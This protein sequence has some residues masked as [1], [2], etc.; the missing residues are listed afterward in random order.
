MIVVSAG[1]QL[2]TLHLRPGGG[3]KSLGKHS[4]WKLGRLVGKYP[5]HLMKFDESSVQS[6][7]KTR[8]R[9]TMLS[10]FSYFCVLFLPCLGQATCSKYLL[11]KVGNWYSI[12]HMYKSILFWFYFAVVWRTVLCICVC[13]C[14]CFLVFWR[15]LYMY[16]CI[17]MYA[18]YIQHKS[19]VFHWFMFV[20]LSCGSRMLW[21]SCVLLFR[22]RTGLHVVRWDFLKQFQVHGEQCLSMW[23]PWKLC[24]SSFNHEIWGAII[25]TLQLKLL[26]YPVLSGM[27]LKSRPSN[28]RHVSCFPTKSCRAAVL[29]AM[30]ALVVFSAKT[31]ISS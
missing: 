20:W 21:T 30:E 5:T 15:T 13:I 17:C 23:N 4:A 6:G 11:L 26:C 24:S 29:L 19:V 7:Q 12:S 3:W 1:W 10:V 8:K 14:I 25:F 31:V 16:I 18:Y 22:W 2:R 28:Q 27:L 9:L